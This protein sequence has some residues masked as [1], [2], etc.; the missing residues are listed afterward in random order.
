MPDIIQTERLQ[1]APLSLKDAP[2]ALELLNSPGWLQFSGDRNVHTLSDAEAYITRILDNPNVL[3]WVAR[4]IGDPQALGFVTKLQ[5]DFL[6]GPDIGF[7]FLDKYQGS[8]YAFEG[9]SALMKLIPGTLYAILDPSN[10]HSSKLLRKLG[11]VFSHERED[12]YGLGHVY[13]CKR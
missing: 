3:Y 1:L 6:P 4:L 2:F 13:L 11:F 9:A 7:A 8:G 12:D 10:E 5:R